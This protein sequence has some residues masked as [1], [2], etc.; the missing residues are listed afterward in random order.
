MAPEADVVVIGAGPGGYPAAIRAAQLG[1]RV[2]LVERDRLG[3]ECL[4]YGCIPSKALIRAGNLVHT[5]GRA[6]EWGVDVSGVSVD[7]RRLQAWKQGVVDRLNQG[8]ARLCE[9]NGVEV[10]YGSARFT[11]PGAVEVRAV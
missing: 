3:G 1:R 5:L 7:F 9:G 11:G 8:V 4:N 2:T 6:K 10:V